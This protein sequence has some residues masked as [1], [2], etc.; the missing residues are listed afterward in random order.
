MSG[1]WLGSLVLIVG[2]LP[3]TAAGQQIGSPPTT[4]QPTRF[5]SSVDLVSVTAVVRDR[6]GRF[7]RDLNQKDF[8][9]AEAGVPRP[10]LDFRSQTDGPVKLAVLFDVSGSM[11]LGSKASDARQAARQLFS[12]MKPADQAAIFVF[13][14]LL[15]QVQGFTSNQTTLQASLDQVDRPYGQTSLYDAVA[16]TARALGTDGGSGQLQQ[17]SAVVVLTDGIDTKSRMTAEHVTT[18]AS[19]IDVPVYVLA[20]MAPIDDPRQL[21][22]PGVF[23]EGAL[24][25]LSQWTGGELFITSAPAHVSVAARQIVDE[26]RHQ[27]VLAFAASSTRTGWRP[28]KVRAR[29]RELT[30]RARAGYTAGGQI[31]SVADFQGT[32]ITAEQ[33]EPY[34]TNVERR[35]VN[36]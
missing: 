8:E 27:Y 32:H 26:L 34:K 2:L 31:G 15:H 21:E 23:D 1:R 3:L 7:V 6:K 29:D 5:R 17:R 22:S 18:I 14:T 19:G 4:D 28:L 24:R 25:N 16:E 30:V 10:I 12:A 20:V 35:R 33:V 11:R 36:D 9:V 13:D